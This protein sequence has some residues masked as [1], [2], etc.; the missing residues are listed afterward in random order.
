LPA[1]ARS[2]EAAI[3]RAWE[4]WHN[5][6]GGKRLF[7]FLLSR[8]VPYT[9]TIRPRVEEL[10]PGYARV[11]IRDRRGVRQHMG[12]VHAIALA[13]LAEAA[14]GLAFIYALPADARTILQGIAVEYH[15]KARGRITAR[16]E[17]PVLESSEEREVELEATLRDEDGEIVATARARWLVGPRR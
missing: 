11:S 8:L 12:S 17:A 2:P 14:T 4:R 1:P 5:R 9:G 15:R 16:A 7:S 6:P 10:G 3:R 13:N